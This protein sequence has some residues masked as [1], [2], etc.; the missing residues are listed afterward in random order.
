MW[1]AVQVETGKESVI[2]DYCSKLVNRTTYNDIFV[3]RFNKVKKFYGKWHQESKVMFPGYIF[4]DTDT[5]EQVYEALKKYLHSQACS[6]ETRTASCQLKE[7]R[8]SYLGK[9]SMTITK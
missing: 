3:L 4:I 7:A 1:Y 2:K 6:E 8:K 9:W 5:P